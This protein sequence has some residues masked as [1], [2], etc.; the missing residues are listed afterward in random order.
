MSGKREWLKCWVPHRLELYL[1]PSWVGAPRPLK[2]MLERLE[3][4]HM[5]HGG[6]NN[7]E[8]FVSYRQFVEHGISRKSIRRT[9]QL[10][11]ALGLMAVRYDEAEGSDIRPPNAY[12]ITYLPVKGKA[13]SDEWKSVPKERVQALLKAYRGDEKLAVQATRRA[14]A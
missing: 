12:L 14:A 8:L 3:I 1:S 5:R 2:V 6:F 10:G 11:V 4:E 13:P 9:Q 7:G